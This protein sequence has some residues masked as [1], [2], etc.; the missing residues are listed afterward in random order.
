[1]KS[2]LVMLSLFFDPIIWGAALFIAG[3]VVLLDRF[4]V[5][6]FQKRTKLDLALVSNA[7]VAK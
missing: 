1:M 5:T 3:V 4:G 2:L 7:V 6:R